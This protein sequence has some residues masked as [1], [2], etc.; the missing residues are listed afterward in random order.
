MKQFLQI[1]FLNLLL[2]SLLSCSGQTSEILN[3]V[4]FETQAPNNEFRVCIEVE[5]AREEA[6]HKRGLQLRAS[7]GSNSG[8]LFIFPLSRRHSFWMK[9]TLIPLDIIWIDDTHRVVHIESNVP[10]CKTDTCPSYSPDEAALYVLEI[11]AGYVKKI[12]IVA[13]DGAEFIF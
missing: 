4:C 10:P 5:L 9:D 2:L 11:N 7:L 8:M 12:G 6:E 3:Q 13:G 1:I